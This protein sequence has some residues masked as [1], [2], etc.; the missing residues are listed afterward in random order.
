MSHCPTRTELSQFLEDRLPVTQQQS[1]EAH[2]QTCGVCQKVLEELTAPAA[3]S[4]ITFPAAHKAVVLEETYRH[5]LACLLQG[6]K[7]S[8]PC[9]SHPKRKTPPNPRPCLSSRDMN[10][11]G[12]W[13]A[14]AWALSSRLDRTS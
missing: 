11:L 10:C 4:H 1:V 7:P 8:P 2:I 3:N 6:Q 14:A 13:A 9:A 5:Q 12:N